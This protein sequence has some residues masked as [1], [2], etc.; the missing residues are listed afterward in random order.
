MQGAWDPSL[1]GELRSHMPYGKAKKRKG[2]KKT[3]R[4]AEE[5]YTYREHLTIPLCLGW[6]AMSS[7]GSDLKIPQD[8]IL[9]KCNFFLGISCLGYLEELLQLWVHSTINWTTFIFQ[10]FAHHG[11]H[12]SG[13][14]GIDKSGEEIFYIFG[15]V[16]AQ[17]GQAECQSAVS[18]APG[19]ESFLKG[20][21]VLPT[22]F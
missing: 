6:T 7:A 2:K 13:F 17:S 21:Q 10:F 16:L 4:K 1:V 18:Q 9:V 19:L 8:W 5:K 20:S 22:G 15:P 14:P 12:Q 11:H 3:V